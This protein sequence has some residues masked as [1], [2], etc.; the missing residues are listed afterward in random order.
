MRTHLFPNP[1]GLGPFTKGGAGGRILRV[2]NLENSGP[3]SLRAAIEKRGPRIIVFEV[4]GIIDLQDSILRIKDPFLTIAGQT[5]PS[6]GI[7]IIKGGIQV[8]THDVIIQHIRV[9]PGEAGHAKKSGWEV[10]GI[11]STKG[12]H[13]LIV[14]HCSISW[15]TD[16]NLSAS[17]P[18]FDGKD[19][20]E[21]R[22]N[23]S[24]QVLF[25]NCIIS[26]G[27]SNSSHAKG[28]HSKGSLIHDNTTDIIIARNLY[29]HN[30]SR[31]PFFKGGAQGIVVNNY[32]Y[33]PGVDAIHYNLSPEEWQ[34]HEWIM[35][36]LTV[37]GNMIEFGP[38]TMKDMPLGRFRG[39]C[40]VYW[41]DNIGKSRTGKQVEQTT[42]SLTLVQERPV[43]LENLAVMLSSKVKAFVLKNAGAR[44]WDRDEIDQ[45]I[46][47][48]AQKGTGR[49]ID[50]EQEVGGYPKALQTYAEFVPN[51]WNLRTM[52]RK[53][54]K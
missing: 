33:N 25:S 13:K 47:S 41:Q 49:I 44:P 4:G 8:A 6:P 14:D 7:T 9:R 36:K 31:N 29:A 12:A 26:E 11:A 28:P 27:L 17:G 45:R 10:D 3:G 30:V 53:G 15:A 42:G 48:E 37:E 16:E 21:W 43:W 46:I 1:G 35:G 51:E 22:R 20:T 24:H 52:E 2:E 54:K 32:I 38:N 18:R 19:S 23:T 40:D 39:P 5:A 50:S 34:G